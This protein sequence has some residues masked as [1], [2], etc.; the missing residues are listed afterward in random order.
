[1]AVTTYRSFVDA[2]EALSITD[3]VRQ[4]TQGPPVAQPAPA[5]CPFQYVRYPGTDEEFA[6]VFG[7]QGGW[8]DLRAELVIGVEPV[9]QNVTPENFDDTVDM[10]DNV[11]TA[12][13]G[14]TCLTKSKL[15]WGLRQAI[16]TV[17]GQEYWAVIAT[18]RG[19]G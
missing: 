11:A 6:I 18:V 16:D 14:A 8:A 13:R 1:M 9:G 4:Y 12:L 2:L 19:H 10:M 17:A 5:D 3:V 7:E 15:R